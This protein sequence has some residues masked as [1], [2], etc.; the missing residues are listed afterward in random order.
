M[1]VKIKILM[2]KKYKYDF[3]FAGLD[4]DYIYKSLQPFSAKALEMTINEDS[5]D[6]LGVLS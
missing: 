1:I 4:K 5:T 3:Y 2:R 6:P